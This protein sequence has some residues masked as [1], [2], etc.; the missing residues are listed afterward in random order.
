M[1]RRRRRVIAQLRTERHRLAAAAEIKPVKLFLQ[2]HPAEINQHGSET[3]PDA[4]RHEPE[5]S[6][7]RRDDDTE[8]GADEELFPRESQEPF[9][10]GE[11]ER[12]PE[13]LGNGSAQ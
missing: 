4:K 5:T 1:L 11:I 7:N 3:D 2:V 8:E 13:V 12:L 6:K 10:E 9:Y